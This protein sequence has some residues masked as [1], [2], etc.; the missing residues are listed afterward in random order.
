MLNNVWVYFQKVDDIFGKFLNN[1]RVKLIL[2]KF[3]NNNYF[4]KLRI[5]L[6]FSEFHFHCC[7]VSLKFLTNFAKCFE[8]FSETYGTSKGI[9]LI[10]YNYFGFVSG[11]ADRK[12]IE[13]K[14]IKVVHFGVV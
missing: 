3:C 9:I 10:I 8:N 4:T 5:L 7:N 6:I 14:S 2:R 11:F 12:I 13:S 1:C